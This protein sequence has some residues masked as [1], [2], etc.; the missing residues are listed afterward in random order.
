M[1]SLGEK[2]MK[3][4]GFDS[5]V[6]ENGVLKNYF[7]IKD[8]DKLEQV[9]RDIVSYKESILKDN[10][11]RGKFDLKHLQNIHTYLFGDIYPFAGKIR[12]GYLQKG[13]Q[14]F[15]M[16][17]RIIPQSEKLFAQ[18]KKEHY[19]RNTEP[20]KIAGRLAYYLG[21]INA[22]HPFREGN[23][24]TQRIFI[25]QLAREAGFELSFNQV[26][27]EEMIKASIQAH[28]CD[29]SGLEMVIKRGLKPIR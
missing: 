18:L 25:V 21:E 5:H 4:T 16:G 10:Q 2:C 26:T 23:G 17:Y 19:L 14:D 11:I 27:Q 12:D 15:T 28:K 6:D 7:G 3:Y 20:E 1:M 22:I 24:R 9:E 29:Y 8:Q 13:E